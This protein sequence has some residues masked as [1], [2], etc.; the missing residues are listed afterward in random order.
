MTESL[1]RIVFMGTPEFA[2]ASLRALHEEGFP[3]LAVVTAP[4]KPSGRGRR[5]SFTPVKEYALTHNLTLLQPEKLRDKDF[6]KMLSD[7]NADIFVVVAF[8]MLPEEVWSIPA[9]GT[10]NLHA[11]LLPHYRGAAPINHAVMNGETRTGVTTF[12]IDKEIDTGKILLARDTTIGPEED[13]G[14]LHDRLMMMGTELVTETA[15]GLYDGRLTPVP[16]MAGK[17]MELKQAPKI[18]PPDMIIDWRAP[19]LRVHDMIRGLSPSPGAVATLHF[20]DKSMRIKIY[21]SRILDKVTAIPGS[22]IVENKSR[23]IISC[24]VGALEILSI[25]PEG[26]KRMTAAEFLRGFDTTGCELA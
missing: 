17:D 1:P 13:A 26:R 12:L 11:S 4:D 24:S 7:L 19:A 10:F 20:E 22:I 9:L 6:I 16:Q 21:A 23:L 25:Q 14:E 3:V 2:V 5:I 8:R 18:F 15:K